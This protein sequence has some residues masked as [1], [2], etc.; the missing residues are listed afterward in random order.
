MLFFYISACEFDI[1][2]CEITKGCAKP[3]G[4][5]IDTVSSTQCYKCG[6]EGHFA[7]GCTKSSK[8]SLKELG[9][10]SF[11]RFWLYKFSHNLYNLFDIMQY[12][13]WEGGS[14]TPRRVA[15]ENIDSL[16]FRS[17]PRD[18]GKAQKKKKKKSQYEVKYEDRWNM[19]SGKS[20]IK[21]GWIV[22]DAGDSS[23]RKQKAN[24]WRSP[25]TS[26]RNSHK[27]Y[28]SLSGGH[29]S[30]SQS[31]FKKHKSYL[32][33]PNSNAS[34]SSHHQGYSTPRYYGKSLDYFGRT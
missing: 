26:S 34:A 1:G 32:G 23:G 14:S 4:E 31:P 30:M 17:V 12:D 33:T 8:V 11:F 2:F 27:V 21:G 24:G 5:L 25:S 29:Y 13:R 20:K 28:S 19:K 7:R 10:N 3:R 18:F 16:G 15:N 22:D 9:T 6:E